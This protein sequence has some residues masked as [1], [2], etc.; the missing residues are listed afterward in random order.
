MYHISFSN[1]FCSYS[2]QQL[3]GYPKSLYLYSSVYITNKRLYVTKDF[4][5][6]SFAYMSILYTT[7][8]IHQQ[9]L[10]ECIYQVC[11][12]DIV[13]LNLFFFSFCVHVSFQCHY[14]VFTFS[15]LYY[16]IFVFNEIIF[17]F[18]K[19]KRNFLLSLLYCFFFFLLKQL[20][21]KCT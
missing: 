20:T 2:R 21:S 15:S 3:Y 17:S 12:K 16:S 7:A 18:Y 5:E 14:C 4:S 11:N 1:A 10:F 9:C 8:Y 6:M 13:I 19:N